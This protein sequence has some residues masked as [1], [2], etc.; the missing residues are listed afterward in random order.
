MVSLCPSIANQQIEVVGIDL[1]PVSTDV[2]AQAGYVSCHNWCL[3]LFIG[4]PVAFQSTDTTLI[5]G[6]PCPTLTWAPS[7]RASRARY[8]RNVLVRIIKQEK[9]TA[10]DKLYSPLMPLYYRL[11][12]TETL[13]VWTSLFWLTVVA[14]WAGRTTLGLRE[15]SYIEFEYFRF[16]ICTIG[17]AQDLRISLPA[18]AVIVV[19]MTIKTS[20]ILD[21]ESRVRFQTFHE[22]DATVDRP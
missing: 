14:F 17:G 10:F 18:T 9:C 20:W 13:L 16:Y 21:L 15:L 19:H 8:S 22:R 11:S 1:T 2:K 3:Q 4:S 12:F 6:A 5:C 7:E